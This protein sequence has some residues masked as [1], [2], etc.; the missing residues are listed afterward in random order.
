MSARA[1]LALYLGAGA[2]AVF[3]LL[4]LALLTVL[5]TPSADRSVSD[6]L[7]ALATGALRDL[8]VALLFALTFLLVLNLRRKPWKKKFGRGAIH[9]FIALGIFLLLFSAIAEMLFWDEFD[10]RLNGIALYY[11]MFPREVIGNLQQSFNI[12]LYMP[13]VAAATIAVTFL[14]RRPIARALDAAQ[15][16][17]SR[18]RELG[19]ALLA[20]A[21]VLLPVRAVPGDLSANRE[22]NQLAE[23]GWSTFIGAALTNDQEYDGV[24]PGMDEGEAIRTVRKLVAQSNTT[25]LDP[26]N[27]RSIRRWVDNGSAPK[28]LNIVI[29]TNESFGSKFIT[30]LDNHSG[31]VWT[32]SLDKLSKESL[33][34]TNIYASGDRTVRGLEATETG[35]TPIPGISTARRAESKDMYS[36]PYLLRSFG[37]QSAV[38][39]GGHA[40]FDNMG[41]FWS[42]IGFQPVWDQSF[43]RHESFT[44]AWGV[45]DEDLYTEALQRMDEMAADKKPF[46]LTMMTVSNHRPYRFPENHIK[47]DPSMTNR[48]NSARYADWAYG[49]FIERAK[50]HG[51]FDNTV[52]VFV[53][54]HS[55]KINGAAQVPLQDMRIPILIYSP[56]NIAPRSVATLGAQID[57]IPTLLGELGFSYVS[58]FFGKD[59]TLEP[60]D[61]GF[62]ATAHNFSVAFGRP[63]H[64][65]V[66]QPREPTLGYSFEAGLTPLKPETPDPETVKEAIALTQTAHHMFYAHQ[67][68]MPAN[69]KWPQYTPPS[70][71]VAHEPDLTL[72][73]VQ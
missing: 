40:L 66:L 49:D 53:A 59:L 34:F 19:A 32:P 63:G 10:S 23:N 3:T 21:A 38:L 4:R 56:K 16:R 9:V 37:Y 25:F 33:F 47:F 62:I 57:L 26:E 52:F 5:A 50:Q 7:L 30:V 24:Y 61:G 69:G 28:K 73:K 39:Y 29:V 20:L 48:E 14:I 72:E 12:A 6:I 42:G 15:P 8:G 35:F 45:S 65:A 31:K 2:F 1:A 70:A 22:V 46:L 27:V 11:L 71:A 67:Y 58:P 44:T 54:D 51:W 68:H 60:A 36:L 18:R 55:E 17:G 13:M 64:V 41:T 43:I